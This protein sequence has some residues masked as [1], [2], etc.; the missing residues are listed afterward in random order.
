MESGSNEWLSDIKKQTDRLAALTADLVY[1]SRMEESTPSL[2][3]IDFS[4]SDVIA[5]TAQSFA[6]PAQT[7][8][9]QLTLSVAP[10]L[11]LRG[12][13]HAITQLVSIL[14]DNA[15]KYTPSGGNI[16]LSLEKNTKGIALSV[17]NAVTEPLDKS[18]L[19]RLF[20]RFYR[21]NDTRN[22]R[23]HG[24]GLSIAQAVVQNHGGRIFA[25]APDEHTLRI[26]AIFS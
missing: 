26:T 13:E 7:E 1:L 19:N 23:G 24:I 15:I 8:N 9:K 3:K 6:A 22:G 2:V 12:D 20:D 25:Q 5:E 11:T 16:H 14:L 10:M 21:P 18:Q 4:M 17:T